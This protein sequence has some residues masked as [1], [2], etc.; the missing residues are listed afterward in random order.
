MA[1]YTMRTTQLKAL[2]AEREQF[3]R[4]ERNVATELP[5]EFSGLRQQDGF[6]GVYSFLN[7]VKSA[8][9]DGGWKKAGH[10]KKAAAVLRIH[11]RAAIA[12]PGCTDDGHPTI[13]AAARG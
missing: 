10:P 7:T 1:A 11:K 4:V 2:A 12:I 5:Q 6:S 8:A 13:L 3:A 9:H